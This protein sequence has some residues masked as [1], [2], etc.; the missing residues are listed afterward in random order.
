[1]DIE[2][3]PLQNKL[4]FVLATVAA[5]FLMVHELEI[6]LPDLEHWIASSGALAPLA[7]IALFVIA[8]P[9]FISV[10]TLCFVAGL[11]FPLVPAEFYMIIATYLA[12][13]LIFFLARHLF[14]E[15]VIALL[16]KHKKIAALDTAITT[17]PFKL[18]F[19]LRLTPLPFAIL[20]YALAVTEV[21]FWPYFMATT[22]ILIY[23]GSLVYMGY[24][25]KHLAGLMSG[26]TQPSSVSYPM[27]ITGL[28][29]LVLVLFYVSRIASDIL[30]QVEIKNTQQ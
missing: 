3:K 8:T 6:H 24:T 22:G 10:D 25:T 7:F 13:A 27:L 11:L 2:H 16:A 12:S 19:L 30:K 29:I 9:L 28:L 20:S 15:K 21:K 1:M 23:N 14:K 18:M 5:I 4:A 26:S 17:E